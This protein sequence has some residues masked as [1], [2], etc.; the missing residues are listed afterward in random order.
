M[1]EIVIIL[2]FL[3]ISFKHFV[4]CHETPVKLVHVA[5]IC[6]RDTHH[7][8]RMMNFTALTVVTGNTDEKMVKHKIFR[9]PP[10]FL[11]LHLIFIQISA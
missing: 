10:I 11:K 4:N 3:Q 9:G 8:K 6:D 7:S 2:D 1:N 5:P